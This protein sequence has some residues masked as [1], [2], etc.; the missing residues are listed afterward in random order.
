MTGHSPRHKGRT[1]KLD[2][3]G[4]AMFLN[5]H[6]SGSAWGSFNRSFGMDQRAVAGRL[7]APRTLTKPTP[8]CASSTCN[9]T[10]SSND[11]SISL[12]VPF[13]VRLA[14]YRYCNMDQVVG[15]ALVV[16][17]RLMARGVAPC[18]VAAS[19]P[20]SSGAHGVARAGQ[21]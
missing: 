17:R 11:H 19:S 18:G 6:S 10:S 5:R 13:V 9:G 8:L 15:Q 1:N 20:T 7:S 16:F 21:A 2:R 4:F 14:T 12:N 3:V